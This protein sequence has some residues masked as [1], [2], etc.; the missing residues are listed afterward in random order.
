MF[1]AIGGIAT[2]TL[3][4]IIGVMTGNLRTTT[5]IILVVFTVAGAYLAVQSALDA[6]A[7][8]ETAKAQAQEASANLAAA[9]RQLEDLRAALSL[10][11]VSVG[12]LGK[13][14]ELSGGTKYYVRI[15]AD[16]EADRL[17]PFLQKLRV[18]FKGANASGMVCIR[19]PRADS[20]NYELVFGQGLDMAAAEVFHRLATSHRLPPHGQFAYIF[21]ESTS[22]CV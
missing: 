19:E 5:R 6:E 22:K 3:I 2:A 14:N 13:L 1:L 15:A 8:K 12:D 18:N 17:K 10:I 11:R 20:K 7:S 9:N 16:T 21:P 4:S